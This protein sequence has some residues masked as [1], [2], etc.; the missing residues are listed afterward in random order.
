MVQRRCAHMPAPCMETEA[1]LSHQKADPHV[2]V[3]RGMD[4]GVAGVGGPCPQVLGLLRGP[5]GTQER[6][7]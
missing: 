6:D 1:A 4:I 7:L 5:A 2:P 3:V